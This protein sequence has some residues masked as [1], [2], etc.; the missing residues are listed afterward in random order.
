MDVYGS[1]SKFPVSV[2]SHS[3]VP[4]HGAWLLDQLSPSA[5]FRPPSIATTTGLDN[6]NGNDG[7]GEEKT[8]E[9]KK[10]KKKV[11]DG[12]RSVSGIPV[13]DALDEKYGLLSEHHRVALSSLKLRIQR[14]LV[15]SRIVDSRFG[16]A[17]LPSSPGSPG[18][19]ESLPVREGRQEKTRQEEPRPGLLKDKDEDKEGQG[20]QEGQ[21]QKGGGVVC[22]LPIRFPVFPS[23]SVLSAL[24]TVYSYLVV[25]AAKSL[26]MQSLVHNR[27]CA[28]EILVG[29]LVKAVLRCVSQD[30][31]MVGIAVQGATAALRNSGDSSGAGTPGSHAKPIKSETRDGVSLERL[32]PVNRLFARCERAAVKC[33]AD[34]AWKVAAVFHIRNT[35]LGTLFDEKFSAAQRKQAGGND[36][37]EKQV[38]GLFTRI[39]RKQVARLITVGYAKS[40]RQLLLKLFPMWA[41]ECSR[42]SRKG[43][44][45]EVPLPVELGESFSNPSFHLDIPL[46]SPEE[47]E[48]ESRQPDSQDPDAEFS[49][50]VQLVVLN[51]V[52][53]DSD[54]PFNEHTRSFGL[55]DDQ[56]VP[57]LPE[58]LYVL[59]RVDDGTAAPS[60]WNLSSPLMTESECAVTG[61][62]VPAAE[63]PDIA[64]HV[65]EH[66]MNLNVG[67]FG[68][69]AAGMPNIVLSSIF[70]SDETASNT[71]LSNFEA[72]LQILRL[73]WAYELAHFNRHLDGFRYRIVER[74][75]REARAALDDTMRQYKGRAWKIWSEGVGSALV[76]TRGMVRRAR[77]RVEMERMSTRVIRTYVDAKPRD[78]R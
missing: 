28:R 12:G 40:P 66:G 77:E 55:P 59:A 46:P 60:G 22:Q 70:T 54:T 34:P 9:K 71:R 45:A 38:K 26:Q 30:V 78:K 17:A 6:G 62:G 37:E 65:A 53:I 51:R 5:P 2:N 74:A 75:T 7:E 58:F 39:D 16:A 50:R 4:M 68:N 18:A 32:V 25:E 43:L 63:I 41:I 31:S 14:L 10:K 47:V 29:R 56:D 52:L 72:S 64:E 23:A 57:A 42:S 44:A 15:A 11:E 21:R 33:I 48:S 69:M 49:R 24:D 20:Q 67:E 61:L 1:V 19:R 76:E 8:E 36:G 27:F 73:Q 35:L 3:T 13:L